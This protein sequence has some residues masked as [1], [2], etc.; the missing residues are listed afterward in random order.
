MHNLFVIWE[1]LIRF[2]MKKSITINF[3]MNVVLTMSSFIFPLITF[4]YISRIL[5]P[6]GTGKVTF[7]TSVVAYFSMFA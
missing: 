7:A 6:E 3:I 1:E 5:L 2:I 4:P